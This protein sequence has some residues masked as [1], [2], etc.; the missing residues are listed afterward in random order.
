MIVAIIFACE[1][2]FWILIAAGLVARYAL[3]RE[4]LGGL[5]L[6][7]TP[8][9]DVILLVFVSIDIRR[10]AEFQGQHALAALYLGCSLAFGPDI[11]RWADR[12][13]AERFAGQPRAPKRIGAGHAAQERQGW[14]KHALAWTIAT[15]VL[16]F[17]YLLAG[18]PDDPGQFFELSYLWLFILGIDF[19]WSFSY[20]IK[21]RES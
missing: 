14:L 17:L 1:F 3:K 2:L 9:V 8:V 10:G 18:R 11:L 16:G 21:P 7:A 15:I 6:A 19:I 13:V 5:L 4:Q 12:K 20:T